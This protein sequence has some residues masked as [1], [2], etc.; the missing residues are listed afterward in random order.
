MEC[1][2]QFFNSLKII[3]STCSKY[4]H[5]FNTKDLK[6]YFHYKICYIKMSDFFI[7]KCYF[8]C[9]L[10]LNFTP[11]FFRRCIVCIKITYFLVNIDFDSIFHAS[12]NLDSRGY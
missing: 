8:I 5:I 1:A 2:I 3:Y 7:Q 6:L 10:I 4:A 11:I 9:F 12:I